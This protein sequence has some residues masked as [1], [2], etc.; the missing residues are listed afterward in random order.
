MPEHHLIGW[1]EAAEKALDTPSQKYEIRRSRAAPAQE[2]TGTNV[3]AGVDLGYGE[4][5]GYAHAY[6]G[7]FVEQEFLPE[8]ISGKTF[9]APGNNRIESEYR[10]RLKKLWKEK[11]GY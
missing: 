6:E 1:T 10:E 8:N 5:Y 11:Y 3:N 7:N 9:Y 2:I 4:N